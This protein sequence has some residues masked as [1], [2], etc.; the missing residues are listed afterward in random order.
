MRICESSIRAFTSGSSRFPG[1]AV[2]GGSGSELMSRALRLL[3]YARYVIPG[4]RLAR[5]RCR[6]RT[7]LQ[8]RWAGSVGDGTR[9]VLYD[10][11]E[12][13]RAARMW[14]MLRAFGFD[15][16]AVM[17][18]GWMAWQTERRPIS[19]QSLAMRKRA[20]C[21]RSGAASTEG[22]AANTGG[23]AVISGGLQRERVAHHRPAHATLPAA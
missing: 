1:C 23:G 17:N 18:G 12:N 21:V 11:R 10:A 14:W 16:A 9:V 13:M 5:S 2:A 15:S 19:S 6:T 22:S 20:S 7:G 4:R 8:R 3:I